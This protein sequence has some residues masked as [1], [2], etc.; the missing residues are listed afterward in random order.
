M[1]FFGGLDVSIDETAICVVVGD[2][3]ARQEVAPS[4]AGLQPSQ[5]SD[6]KPLQ[7]GNPRRF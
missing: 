2:A 4:D 1:E 6:Q 3:T 5:H 7:K